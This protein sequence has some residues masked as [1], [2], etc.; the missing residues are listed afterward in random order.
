MHCLN[1]PPADIFL[2]VSTD[3][4]LMELAKAITSTTFNARFMKENADSSSIPPQASRT[5]FSKLVEV[6]EAI[7]G[8][9]PPQQNIRLSDRIDTM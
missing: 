8:R 5:S 9:R 6:A 4:K 7:S 3:A 1:T 2:W